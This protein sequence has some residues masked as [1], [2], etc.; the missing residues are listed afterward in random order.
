MTDW[1]EEDGLR[2]RPL[3]PFGVEIDGD[4]SKP[5]AANAA[6]RF[7]ELFRDF[8][9]IVTRD[10]N[11]A[12]DEQIALMEHIGP[13][14]R[15]VD[16]VGRISSEAGHAAARAELTF[17]AD[18]AFGP[19]PLDALSLHAVDVVDG[20]S[21]TRFAHA[22]R[23]CAELPAELRARLAAAEVDMIS[24]PY[25]A[26][27]GRACDD[28]DPPAMLRGN[29]PAI[30]VN[31]RTG[32]AC[33]GISEM[34]AASV[35]GMDW[36]ASRTLLHRVFDRLYAPE[37]VVEHVWH[38]GDIVIWDNLT[39]QHARGSI[40]TAGRRILQRVTVGAKG[41]WDMYPELFPELEAVHHPAH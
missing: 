18:S 13:V 15:R 27:T 14:Q 34:H 36:E 29:R 26:T 7:R 9:L 35:I 22:E 20:A 25:D 38:R 3:E 11:L 5:L 21:S 40:A 19:C 41:L 32:H 17:H 8:G 30:L 39:F 6:A 10:Q 33:V 4:L 37:N 1:R 28:R 24:P 16:G 23:A 2:W 12:I 31:P